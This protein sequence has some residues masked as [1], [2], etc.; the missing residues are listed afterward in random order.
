M[1]N[2]FTIDKEKKEFISCA[3]ELGFKDNQI[4]YERGYETDWCYA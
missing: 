1:R 4:G 3:K 2:L